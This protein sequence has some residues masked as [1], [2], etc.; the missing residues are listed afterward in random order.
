MVILICKFKSIFKWISFGTLF[1]M[2]QQTEWTRM[3]KLYKMRLVLK[4][5][6]GLQHSQ[7]SGLGPPTEKGW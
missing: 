5:G 1:Y 6:T 4:S 2:A 7:D 3:D